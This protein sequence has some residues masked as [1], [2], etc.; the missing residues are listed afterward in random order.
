MRELKELRELRER[1]S[2]TKRGKVE[3]VGQR[4]E[5]FRCTIA[6]GDNVIL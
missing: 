4:G 5:N 1:G 2:R 3:F 6:S